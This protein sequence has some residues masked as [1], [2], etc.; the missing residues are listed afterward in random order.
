[1]DKNDDISTRRMLGKGQTFF[2]FSA[3]DSPTG[4]FL[5]GELIILAGCPGSGKTTFALH[6]A[7]INSV[8]FKSD[9]AYLRK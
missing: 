5:N 7:Q 6:I 9:M 1:M 4:G 3:L 2:G 8:D